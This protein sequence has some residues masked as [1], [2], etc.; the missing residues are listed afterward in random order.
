MV[1]EFLVIIKYN[2]S[3]R[4][5]QMDMMRGTVDLKPKHSNADDTDPPK[6]FTF[7]AVYDWK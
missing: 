5:I 3:Y 4:V 2:H 1:H 6:T 7:D